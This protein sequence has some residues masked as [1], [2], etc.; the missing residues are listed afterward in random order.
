VAALA[1]RLSEAKV[2]KSKTLEV[3]DLAQGVVKDAEE[4]SGSNG[5]VKDE[6]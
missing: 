5:R 4:D 6:L 1:L 2:I 3:V